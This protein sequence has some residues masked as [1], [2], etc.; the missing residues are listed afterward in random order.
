MTL[1]AGTRLGPYEIVSALGAG[2]MGEVY[3]ARDTRLD[4]EVAVK[5]LPAALAGNAD[6]LARFQ[7]EARAVAALSHPNILAIFDMG[8]HDGIDYAV[9]ELLRG[10]TLRDALD[11]GP[12]PS[13]R[14]IQFA[15]QIAKGLCAAHEKGIVHRDLKPE[16]VFV[17]R[18]GDVK[19]LDFGLARRTESASRDDATEAPTETRTSPGTVMG[20][21][22]YMSPE[23]VRGE[24][25]DPRSDIFS[26]GTVLYEMLTGRRAFAR[27]SSA[28]TMAAI[29]MNDPPDIPG[30][31][32][33]ISPAMAG[34]LSHCLEKSVQRRYQTARDLLFNLQQFGSGAAESAPAHSGGAPSVAVL[35]F[36]NFGADAESDF[37]ADGMTEDVIANL[38]KVRSMK[39]ISRASV[40]PFRK[41]EKSLR[42][43]GASLGAASILDGSIRRAGNR[44]RIVAQLVDARTDEHLW[45]DTYDRDLTD[46][47]A[48]Q[49]DVAMQIAA[50][51]KAELSTDEVA[52][53]EQ[54]PTHDPHA[55]QLF[56]QGRHALSRASEEGYRRGIAYLEQAIAEDPRLAAAHSALAFIYSE[57]STAQGAGTI[58]PAEAFAKAKTF[59]EKALALDPSLGEAHSVLASLRFMCDYDWSGAEKEFQLALSLSPGSADVYDRYGW[60]CSAMGRFDDAIRMVR[61]AQELDPLAH[62]S[63]IANELLRSGRHEEARDAARK[64]IAFEPDFARGHSILGWACIFLGR[65][66][67]GLAALE[68]AVSL[69]PESTL[70]TAQLGQA[71]ALAGREPEAREILRNL[72]ALTRER[73][74]SPYH[75]AYVHTGLGEKEEAIDWLEKAF[76]ERSGAVYGI[77]GSFL[78]KSLHGHPRFQALLAK[79][80]LA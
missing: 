71:Y 9:M 2:G 6:A 26:F 20:T 40:M 31:G 10:S 34:I 78:F 54:K 8:R 42:E 50:A 22:A 56:L 80:N 53:I 1:A 55:Y 37:F 68:H 36:L 29:L 39:V 73:Y 77:K 75:F 32:I 51:L 64:V 38:A 3:K 33:S 13:A 60:M 43:I 14:A 45:A 17:T 48:I 76:E 69:T 25:L 7:K 67:E 74:V 79:M 24:P 28:E 41:R 23:Q 63:D 12:L 44:V 66:A 65:T 21:V 58:P 4:R 18:D 5:V 27:E 49:S 15:L 19:I 57:L 46:I 47:F 59:A 11:S 61:R 16:N 62:R 70:F 72:H 52:R 35:P 30:S